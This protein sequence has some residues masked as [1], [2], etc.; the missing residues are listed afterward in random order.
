MERY[1]ESR[2]IHVTLFR[3][4]KGWRGVGLGVL[5]TTEL[6]AKNFIL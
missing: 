3:S 5:L 4:T 2:M 6:S 1:I